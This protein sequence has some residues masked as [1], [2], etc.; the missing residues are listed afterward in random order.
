MTAF[1]PRI[2]PPDLPVPEDDGAA[3]HL[4]GLEVPS[5]SLQ[6]TAGPVDLRNAAA[7]TLVLYI[8]PRTGR[9]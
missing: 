9:P 1:D 7:G 5:L 2:L 4:P 3:D 8:Y 6:S